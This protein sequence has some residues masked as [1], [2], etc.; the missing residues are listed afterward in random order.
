[1]VSPLI[2]YFGRSC[3]TPAAS[4]ARYT[5]QWWAELSDFRQIRPYLN[6]NLVVKQLTLYIGLYDLNRKE[7]CFCCFSYLFEKSLNVQCIYDVSHLL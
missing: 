1:M 7:I 2:S 3:P 5:I 4:N 6:T